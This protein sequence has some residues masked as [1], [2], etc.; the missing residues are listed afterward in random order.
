MF[1][2]HTPLKPEVFVK[3][4]AWTCVGSAAAVTAANTPSFPGEPQPHPWL[5]GQTCKR[6]HP[7]IQLPYHTPFKKPTAASLALGF[8]CHFWGGVGGDTPTTKN[9]PLKS[10]QLRH[11]SL[12]HSFCFKA[13]QSTAPYKYFSINPCY[14][15]F[16]TYNLTLACAEPSPW[17]SSKLSLSCCAAS[18]Y[19]SPSQNW[20]TNKGW[21]YCTSPLPWC[22]KQRSCLVQ[23]GWPNTFL[24]TTAGEDV[25]SSLL[26]LFI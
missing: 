6:M 3:F 4:R 11:Y 18:N 15:H 7:S 1:T 9:W 20:N 2:S 17:Q 26:F 12:Q 23:A 25:K 13:I 24:V 22:S 14:F 21:I 16:T 19:L 8:K 10:L 5:A